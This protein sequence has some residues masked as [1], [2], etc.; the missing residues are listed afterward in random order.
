M[1]AVQRTIYA[2]R[3][4][5]FVPGCNLHVI[6]ISAECAWRDASLRSRPAARPV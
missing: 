3:R 6:L 1:K 5:F 4:F 2:W